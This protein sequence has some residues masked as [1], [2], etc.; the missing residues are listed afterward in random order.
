MR[1]AYGLKAQ[2]VPVHEAGC[3]SECLDP[4][5]AVLLLLLLAATKLIQPDFGVSGLE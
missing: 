2:A 3:R 1:A 4:G 5:L